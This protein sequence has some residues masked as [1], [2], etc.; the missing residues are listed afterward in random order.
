MPVHLYGL[1]DNTYDRMMYGM[2][3]R[4]WKEAVLDDLGP[5]SWH[6][7]KDTVEN[8]EKFQNSQ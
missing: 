3:V 8:S 1:Y 2:Y 4:I 7:T 6:S 5:L